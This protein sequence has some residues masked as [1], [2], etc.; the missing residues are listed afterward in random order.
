MLSIAFCN[1][2]HKL[3]MKNDPS[4]L[5]VQG[6]LILHDCSHHTFVHSDKWN[7][8]IGRVLS[9]MEVVPFQFYQSTHNRHHA[10]QGNLDKIDFEGETI[11]FTVND[12]AGNIIKNPVLRFLYL[13]LRIPVVYF[14]TFP[15]LIWFGYFPV[16]SAIKMDIYPFIGM[17]VRIASLYVLGSFKDDYAWKEGL[18]V[19]ALINLFV[20]YF[21]IVIGWSLFHI[22]HSHNP[23]YRE[24]KVKGT[25]KKVDAAIEGATVHIV[26]WWMKIFTMGIEYHA[27]HHFEPGIAGYKLQGI[28]NRITKGKDVD[29]SYNVVK[30]SCIKKVRFDERLGGVVVMNY[31]DIYNCMF[32]ILYDDDT[33][34][35]LSWSESIRK[36]YF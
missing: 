12:V 19:S 35:Y 31:K 9:V 25:Y 29:L 27:I 14:S 8:R 2:D 18:V 28:W 1:I 4:I 13:M 20:G 16:M 22:Q 36:I 32:N 7:E 33:Q 21:G 15:T 24:S 23:C 30:N 10:I 26:P 11:H 5:T 3:K 34:R 17:A 6:F